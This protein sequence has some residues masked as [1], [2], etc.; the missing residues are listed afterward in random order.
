MPRLDASRES[1]P[2]G[3]RDPNRMHDFDFLAPTN[4]HNVF[5]LALHIST[6]VGRSDNA[7]HT[8]QASCEFRHTGVATI[9]C[10]CFPDL[11][12]MLA[13]VLTRSRPFHLRPSSFR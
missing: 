3:H 5:H 4:H 13:T 8:V 2:A 9:S 11:S 1:R 12:K 6:K 7:Q 10:F